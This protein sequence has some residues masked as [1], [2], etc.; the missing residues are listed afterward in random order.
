VIDV[1]K[2]EFESKILPLL[3]A[4]DVT[5][6]FQL[7]IERLSALDD[8]LKREVARVNTAYQG[9]RGAAESVSGGGSVSL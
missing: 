7:I 5:V 3:D 4:F 9:L 1:V 8:E 6:L 2:P